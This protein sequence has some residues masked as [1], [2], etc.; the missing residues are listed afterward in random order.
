MTLP[1]EIQDRLKKRDVQLPLREPD[2]EE[3]AIVEGKTSIPFSTFVQLVLKKKVMSL[4]KEWGDDPII[5]S[6]VLLT[7][8]ANCPQDT[9][10]DKNKII[11]TAMTLGLCLG[12]AFTMLGILVLWTLGVDI[13][14]KE[15][16]VATAALLVVGSAVFASMRIHTSKHIQKLTEHVE[17]VSEMFSK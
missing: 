2:E 11:L 9:T 14:Q 15:L 5:F 4:F 16:L 3:S 12:V 13:G 1:P 17:N 7:K 6:S 10:E 8:I